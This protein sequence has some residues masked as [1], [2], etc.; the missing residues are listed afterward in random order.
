[1]SVVGVLVPDVSSR[2][3]LAR[4]VVVGIGGAAVIASSLGIIA[5]TFAPGPA[6]ARASG[7]WGA[8]VGAGIAIGPLLSALLVGWC[9]AGTTPTGCSRWAPAVALAVTAEKLVSESRS[10]HRRGLDLPGAVLFAGGIS[11]LLAALV[12]G[13]QEVGPNRR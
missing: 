6:R 13:P 10:E 1:M 2:F 4:V 7:V 3:V 8:S 11:A 5:H 12:E 9:T